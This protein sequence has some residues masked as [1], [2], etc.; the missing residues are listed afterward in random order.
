M[1]DLI[2]PGEMGGKE[3]MEHLAAID[4]SV[5]GILISGYAQDGAMVECRAHGF[6][7]A[8]SKPFS[9]QELRATLQAVLAPSASVA[10]R[11]H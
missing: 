9:L 10:W 11:V 3:A 2:V 8:L 5:K 4:P 1:L 6:L 7:A